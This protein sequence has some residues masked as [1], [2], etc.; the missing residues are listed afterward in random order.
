VRA[1]LATVVAAGLAGPA[2][3]QAPST[4]SSLPQLRFE[5]TPDAPQQLGVLHYHNRRT[6]S[7]N[8]Q[9]L[10]LPTPEGEVMVRI[11]NTP[12]HECGA[13]LECP[14]TLDSLETPPG[15]V[16]VPPSVT[17]GE[18]DYVQ[19]RLLRFEGM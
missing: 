18:G 1:L 8:E 12:N 4:L 9:V 16:L 11:S 19:L 2:A 13:G 3:A 14:D 7:L 10:R 5:E 6:A 15:W 17:V